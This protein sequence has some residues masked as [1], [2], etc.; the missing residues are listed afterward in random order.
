MFFSDT[1]LISDNIEMPV[2]SAGTAHLA[3][4]Q[5]SVCV[6]GA[7]AAGFRNIDTAIS[8]GN[9]PAVGA[10]IRS[11]GVD[12][13]DIFLTA[14]LPAE[15]KSAEGVEACVRQYLMDLD[16]GYIDLLLI[17]APMPWNMMRGPK[18]FFRENLE[19]WG[20][21]EKLCAG[22]RVRAIGVANFKDVDL[23]N[24]I[25]NASGYIPAVNQI[26]V[27]PGGS[28]APVLRATISR[29]IVPQGHSPFGSGGCLAHPVILDMSARYGVSPERLCVRFSLQKGCCPVLD[30]R[31]DC[32]AAGW[33]GLGF[34]ISGIDMKTLSSL[35]IASKLKRVSADGK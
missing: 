3:G 1:V 17:H 6:A 12:R 23:D 31:E 34:A 8:Y 28:S 4:S 9:L 7:I 25:H 24:I 16:T 20:R 33:A 27:H 18:R 2:L 19:A 10:G 32:D 35:G 14:K 13:G 29:G 11:S 21:M 22:G 26:R 15:I 5:A 30:L